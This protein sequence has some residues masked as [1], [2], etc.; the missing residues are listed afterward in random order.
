MHRKK[1]EKDGRA[2]VCVLHSP[3]VLHSGEEKNRREVR[4]EKSSRAMDSKIKIQYRKREVF[5]VFFKN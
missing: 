2:F 3:G 4:R 5:Q 1:G